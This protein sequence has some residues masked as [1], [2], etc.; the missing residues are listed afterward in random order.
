MAREVMTYPNRKLGIVDHI[1]A[2][3]DADDERVETVLM[4]STQWSQRIENH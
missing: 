2:S 4:M 3:S 1:V